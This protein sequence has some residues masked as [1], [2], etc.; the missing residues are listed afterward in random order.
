VRRPSIKKNKKIFPLSL[1]LLP[2]LLY[3]DRAFF[4][5]LIYASLS[6]NPN[7]FEFAHFIKKKKKKKPFFALPLFLL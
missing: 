5:E 1:P 4:S 7:F 3:S 2:F 6:L